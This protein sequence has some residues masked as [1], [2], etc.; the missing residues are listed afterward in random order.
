MASS[1]PY[2][3]ARDSTL[4]SWA[5][6]FQTL[7]AASPAT[8][9]LGAP[10]A[11]AITNSFNTWHAAY[12][13]GG[14]TGSP[15]VPINPST[16]TSVTVAAKNSAKFA[17]III[18]RSYA[19]Q[20]RLNPG[21]TNSDK[22]ALGLNLPNNTPSPI[23]VP[24]TFPLLSIVGAGPGTH[25]IRFAD[26]ATPALRA[27]PFGAVGMQLY[28]GVAAAAIVDVNLTDWYAQLT[29]QPFQS[30]F[31]IGDAGKVATYFARWITRGRPVGDAAAQVGPWS[32]PV[33]M[34]IAF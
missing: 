19:A 30:S 4:D 23:P 15:P 17:M 2:I 31:L 18:L 5:D 11:V 14:S 16:F 13:V 12:L 32:A 34:N 27:K 3:P 25:I 9:G 21:V 20:I 8:Y 29:T 24:L 1:A 6:N 7:I 26:S 33:S 10:D 28:R 22:I